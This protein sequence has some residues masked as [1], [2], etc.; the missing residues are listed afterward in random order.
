[1]PDRVNYEGK[2]QNIDQI[3][4]KYKEGNGNRSKVLKHEK[5]MCALNSYSKAD[6]LSYPSNYD[7]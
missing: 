2:N 1:M 3:R 7:A 5:S 4:R 6:E